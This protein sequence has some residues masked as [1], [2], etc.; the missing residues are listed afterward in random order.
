MELEKLVLY[1]AGRVEVTLED[2][3]AVIG[4]AA[5][6][7]LDDM[8]FAAQVDLHAQLRWRSI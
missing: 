6:V 4:D 8:V 3:Q 1:A 7:T 2:A 5:A